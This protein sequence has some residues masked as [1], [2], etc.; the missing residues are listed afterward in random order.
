MFDVFVVFVFS[1]LNIFFFVSHVLVKQQNSNM[2][3][4]STIV[5]VIINIFMA[6]TINTEVYFHFRFVLA[7]S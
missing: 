5:W 6:S 7:R 4:M 3:I 1:V 2:S